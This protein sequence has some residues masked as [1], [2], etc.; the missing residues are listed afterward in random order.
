MADASFPLGER[1]GLSAG[2]VLTTD[3][4]GVGAGISAAPTRYTS[5]NLRNVWSH[6]SRGGAVGTQIQLNGAAQL[7]RSLSLNM[8]LQLQTKKF[9]NVGDPITLVSATDDF[10]VI[11]GYRQQQTS[12]LTYQFDK[13]GSVGLGYSKFTGFKNDRYDQMSGSWSKSFLISPESQPR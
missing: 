11:G 4:H 13:L 8:S 6:Q 2:T 5:V 9:R 1:A 12:S 3:Y 7:S 10:S